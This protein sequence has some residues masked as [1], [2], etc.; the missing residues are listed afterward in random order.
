MHQIDPETTTEPLPDVDNFQHLV[1]LEPPPPSPLHKSHTFGYSTS[2]YKTTNVKS[3][4]H[5][6]LRRI[7][8]FRL[9]NTKCMVLV[10]Q[11]KKLHHSNLVCITFGIGTAHSSMSLSFLGPL[12]EKGEN[13][14]SCQRGK[15][16]EILPNTVGI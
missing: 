5:V 12:V 11:W 9:V 8:S 13:S 6:C 2:V 4:F 10:D 7:H 1:P 3:G 14:C 16:K 15:K